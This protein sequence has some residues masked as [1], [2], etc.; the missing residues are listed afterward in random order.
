MHER[1]FFV[2]ENR[3][4]SIADV[5]Q[6]IV[7]VMLKDGGVATCIIVHDTRHPFTATPGA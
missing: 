5:V 6:V 4:L 2:G 1:L 7:S 3:I